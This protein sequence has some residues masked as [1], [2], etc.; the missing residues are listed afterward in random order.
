MTPL[1]YVGHSRQQL[2]HL[3]NDV[4]DITIPARSGKVGLDV[5]LP[6]PSG[7]AATELA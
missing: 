6:R 4:W 5:A 3:R 7:A 1:Q 2:A